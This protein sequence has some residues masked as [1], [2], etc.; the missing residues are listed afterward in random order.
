MSDTAL[1]NA[2]K[3]QQSDRRTGVG[4]VI[5]WAGRKQHSIAWEAGPA[6]RYKEDELAEHGIE[7]TPLVECV[8]KPAEAVVEEIVGDALE[9]QSGVKVEEVQEIET[10]PETEQPVS[11]WTGEG[12]DALTDVEAAEEIARESTGHE[13]IFLPEGTEAANIRAY[14][15]AYPEA[16]NQEVI[17]ALHKFGLEVSSSQVSTQR[18]KIEK[19]ASEE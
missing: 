2:N 17:A 12:Q 7:V 19:D 6:E 16:T 1:Q 11:D 5:E 14:L 4:F 13:F 15:T 3:Y 8:H 18:K 9:S 10:A